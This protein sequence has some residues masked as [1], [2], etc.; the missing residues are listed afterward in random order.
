MKDSRGDQF[1]TPVSV[2]QSQE[3]WVTLP[4]FSVSLARG[5]A[6]TVAEALAGVGTDAMFGIPGGGAN[7]ELVGAAQDV[8]MRFVLMHGETAACIAA[9][10]FGL[11]RG[12]PGAATVTR[13][14]GAASSVNG[15]AQATLDRAPLLL[16]TDVVPAHQAPRVPH[17][18]IDQRGMFSPVTKWTGTIG[19]EEGAAVVRNAVALTCAAPMGAVHLDFD[20]SAASSAPPSLPD[21][22]RTPAAATLEQAASLLAD[23]Q[24]P[25]LLLGAEAWPWWEQVRSFAARLGC[26][27][28]TT[29]QARGLVS[30]RSPHVAGVFTNGA[31]ERPLL[32]RADLLL[33]VGLDPVEPVP[34]PW[35]FDAPVVSVLPWPLADAYYRPAVEIVGDVGAA[36]EELQ[37]HR[38]AT[39]WADRDVADARNRAR[40]VLRARP[41]RG[42]D[43]ADV[44]S[45]LDDALPENATVTVD[46]GAHMLLIVPLLT[47]TRPRGMLI[48]NGLAT[49][50]FAIP[51]AI[52]AALARPGEP[53]FALTGDGGLGMVLSE[54]ETITRLQLPITVVVFNDAALS[55]IEIKQG[56]GHGGAD[57]VRY[58][59]IDFAAT[60]RAMGMSGVRVSNRAALEVELTAETDG[61]KLIDVSI[62][63]SSYRHVMTVTRG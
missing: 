7:L 5:L 56:R 52:G 48:S 9:S 57:A 12:Q 1:P 3:A 62:D 4:S 8:G 40:D 37:S 15:A 44:V 46:A 35:T 16:V 26:P 58:R 13:G 53:V 61:P 24:R 55:L 30:D 38:D 42:F 11:L 41:V 39:G 50:G 10:T 25:A 60:A 21:P 18:R 54:L 27:V 59:N 51:A 36:L 47:V 33:A 19:A 49:M 14:P 34:A 17:Q 45:V 63:P 22:P 28:F 2:M 29:Y 20:P 32:E 31:I 23:A 43:P 6:A